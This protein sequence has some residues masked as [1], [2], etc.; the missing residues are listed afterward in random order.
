M[1][2]RLCRRIVRERS[3]GFCERCCRFGGLTL[4]H[5]VNR[6]QLSKSRHWEPANCVM[7]CGDGVRGCHGWTGANPT[8]AGVY[9]WHVAPWREPEDVP[10]HWR[11]S[12]WV[13]LRN[14]GSM[15]NV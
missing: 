8:E 9:G 2:E 10:L 11:M 4:H 5:R 14:D 3:E 6:S 1:N 12:N 15:V 7:L 13:L